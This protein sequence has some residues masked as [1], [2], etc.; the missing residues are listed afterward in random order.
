MKDSWKESLVLSE[1]SKIG[2]AEFTLANKVAGKC[3]SVMDKTLNFSKVF[4]IYN[5]RDY[6]CPMCRGALS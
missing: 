1:K 2:D 3:R 4:P 5:T 6:E